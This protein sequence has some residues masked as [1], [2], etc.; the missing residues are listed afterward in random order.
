MSLRRGA[1]HCGAVQFEV[2]V[3]EPLQGSRCNCSICAMKGAVM[4]YVPLA[5]LRVAAGEDGALASYSFNTGAAKHHFC[6]NCGIH[7]FHRT[8]S[9]PHL[10]GINAA[11]LDG[12]D[13]YRDFPVL[14]VNDGVHHSKDHGGVSRSAGRLLF[15]PA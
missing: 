6:R 2:E 10:F 3:A 1:C 11:V 4:V 5:A 9:D 14:N 15:E 13:V 7:C 12:V 8:R